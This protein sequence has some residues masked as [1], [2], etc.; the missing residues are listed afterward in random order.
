VLENKR[1]NAVHGAVLAALAE[2]RPLADVL[3]L[4]AANAV[5]RLASRA[6]LPKAFARLL[7]EVSRSNPAAACSQYL[8]DAPMARKLARRLQLAAL[9]DDPARGETFLQAFVDTPEPFFP[10][11]EVRREEEGIRESILAMLHLHR[12]PT[13]EDVALSTVFHL[14]DDNVS[15][16][17]FHPSGGLKFDRSVTEGEMLGRPGPDELA[18]LAGKRVLLVGERARPQDRRAYAGRRARRPPL[19]DPAIRHGNR[20][21]R[22]GGR[23]GAPLP[24]PVRRAGPRRIAGLGVAGPRAAG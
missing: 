9:F 18:R 20:R 15:G 11:D 19:L 10:R 21:L 6:D 5:A 17:T 4:L 23:R 24:P 22:R 2:G 13:D 14:A 7:A 12:M 1:L 16:E 8:L 3:A